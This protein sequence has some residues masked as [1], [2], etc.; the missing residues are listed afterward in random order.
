MT[1]IIVAL[2]SEYLPQLILK[3]PGYC[4]E[5]VK[6]RMSREEAKD[7]DV[8]EYRESRSRR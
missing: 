6:V 4:G 1:F 5:T 8:I 3:V 2:L 7:S